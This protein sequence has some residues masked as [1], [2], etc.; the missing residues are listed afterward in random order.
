L[1]DIISFE[2]TPD[3]ENP[4]VRPGL[5]NCLKKAKLLRSAVAYWTV[6]PDFVHQFLADRLSEPDGFLCVDIHLPTDIDQL[7]SLVRRG[8]SVRIFCE[9]IT[10]FRNEETHL[11]HTKMLLFWMP[12]RTAE[13]WI[14]SH[15]WTRRALVG[16]NVEAS[17]IVRMPDSSALFSSAVLYLEKIKRICQPF[18]LTRIEFYKNLQRQQI[19]DAKKALEIEAADADSLQGSVITVFGT[20]PDELGEIAALRRVYVSVFEESGNG[21]HI[22]LAKVIQVGIMP[23]YAS[24]ATG[25]SFAAR[26]YAF[27]RGR[28]FPKLL[29][30]SEV[31]QDVLRD[32]NYFVVLDVQEYEPTLQAFDPPSRTDAWEERQ[33]MTSP[34]LARLTQEQMTTLFRN[35]P[36]I[37]RVPAEPGETAPRAADV[38]ERRARREHRLI[39][40]KVLRP[41]GV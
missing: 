3:W 11:I 20:D 27:R 30:I 23:N 2:L 36:A 4:D 5:A 15:N 12:D 37:V 6:P 21:E 35:K 34:L 31:G 17:L 32:A 10:A 39:V 28:T 19:E 25:L 38:E 24:A 29:S 26:R 1:D 7:A 16:G 40:R 14:G 9:D 41:T 22:Y 33:A 13:L 18:D 8:A